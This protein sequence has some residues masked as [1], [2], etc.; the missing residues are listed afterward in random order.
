[1]KI[2]PTYALLTALVVTSLFAGIAG[3]VMKYTV[4]K[5]AGQLQD[6]MPV[7]IP[8]TIIGDDTIDRKSVV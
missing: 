7:S 6:D 3:V 1:M 2:K 8:F 4:C 5:A